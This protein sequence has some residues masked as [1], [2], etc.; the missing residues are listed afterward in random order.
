MRET[1]VYHREN[2][3]HHLRRFP[4]QGITAAVNAPASAIC[5]SG[6]R[7]FQRLSPITGRSGTT[8]VSPGRTAAE[9]TLVD[10]HPP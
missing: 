6:T 5:A 7:F 9:S 10:H 8:I 4:T 2:L 3:L 1:Q